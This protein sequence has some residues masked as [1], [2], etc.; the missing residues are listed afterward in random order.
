[1]L[2]FAIIDERKTKVILLRKNQQ[3]TFWKRNK[4]KLM[5]AIITGIITTTLG[6]VDTL[7]IQSIK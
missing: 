5:V 7:I 2:W 3:E 1:L 4:D 6:I